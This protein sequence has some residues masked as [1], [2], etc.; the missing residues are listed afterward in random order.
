MKIAIFSDTFFP[1]INGVASVARITAKAL[2]DLGNKVMVFTAVHPEQTELAEEKAGVEVVN[3]PSVPFPGYTGER[4]AM[5]L[6][7]SISKMR[8]FKPDV[9]HVHTPMGVGWEA[10]FASTLLGIPLIGTHHTFYDHYLK[11]VKMDFDWAKTMSWKVTAAYYNRCDMILSPSAAL[12]DAMRKTGLKVPA[13]VMPNPVDA[14]MFKPLLDRN[15]KKKLKEQFG[16]PGLSIVYMGRIGYEKNIKGLLDAFQIVSADRPEVRL[17]IVGDGPDR[18]ELEEAVRSK[19]LEDK[20]IFTGFLGDEPL[21]QAL[22]ANDIF[23]TASKSENMPISVL[24]ALA[25]GLPAIGVRAKGIPEI[26]RDGE[27]G[28]LAEPDNTEELAQKIKTLLEDEGLRERFS[29]RSRQIAL[30]YSA[31][32]TAEFLE[33]AY[34]E[35]IELK[36]HHEKD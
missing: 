27:N 36:K 30:E 10:V 15:E 9:I 7:F 22:Q 13:K 31:H 17:M 16:I 5:M 26:I 29:A 28:L 19:N 1:Q 2:A 23:V 6:G 32:R 18:P 34:K 3:L 12:I 33:E 8:K 20:V 25:A 35:A 21:V 24:E 4:A 14:D 11:Y